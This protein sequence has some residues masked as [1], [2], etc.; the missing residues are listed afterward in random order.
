MRVARKARATGK[1]EGGGVLLSRPAGDGLDGPAR[2]D[3]I[4][5]IQSRRAAARTT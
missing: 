2:L 3:M 1:R 5:P 4:Q